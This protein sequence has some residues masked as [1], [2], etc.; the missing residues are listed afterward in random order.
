MYNCHYRFGVSIMAICIDSQ[1]KGFLGV[2]M[3][4][5]HPHPLKEHDLVLCHFYLAVIF[6]WLL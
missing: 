1:M 5:H 3:V 4:H 6:A 2:C